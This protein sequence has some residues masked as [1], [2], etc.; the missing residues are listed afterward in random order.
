MMTD[1]ELMARFCQSRDES[2]F[3]ELVQRFEPK[4]I[5]VMQRFGMDIA[6]DLTQ[7]TFLNVFQHPETYDRR[8]SFQCW[9]ISVAMNAGVDYVR[10]QKA[11]CRDVA[12][13]GRISTR[14]GDID[15]AV[16]D[17]L[18][19]KLQTDELLHLVNRLPAKERTIVQGVYF[20]GKKLK[21]AAAD[22]G[23]PGGS[24]VWTLDSGLERLRKMLTE[25]IEVPAA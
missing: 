19:R 11:D 8:R 5:R 2:L 20:E 17:P 3:A 6:E 25:N 23:V 18:P 10:K 12:R 15:I 13:T 9:I 16:S 24:S 21:E 14:E 7:E 1:E 4:I 22:A